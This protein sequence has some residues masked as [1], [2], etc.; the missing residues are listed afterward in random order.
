[1][2]QEATHTELGNVGAS[3][4]QEKRNVGA[5]QKQEKL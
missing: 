4:K 5:S 3:Q 1:V 2:G